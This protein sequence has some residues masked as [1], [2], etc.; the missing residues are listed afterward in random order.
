MSSSFVQ[1]LT[2]GLTK[3]IQLNKHLSIKFQSNEDI[4]AI[5]RDVP[6]TCF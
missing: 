2:G 4:E 3:K 1:N 6:L 5:D